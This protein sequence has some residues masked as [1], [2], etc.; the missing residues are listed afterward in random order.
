METSHFEQ[1][2]RPMCLLRTGSS[3]FYREVIASLH[4]SLCN[5]V[6][7][8]FSECLS[9]REPV[10]FLV[11]P[12]TAQSQSRSALRTCP[13]PGA[14]WQTD[15]TSSSYPQFQCINACSTSLFAAVAKSP[16]VPVPKAPCAIPIYRFRAHRFL[17]AQCDFDIWWLW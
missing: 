4:L 8:A 17:R 6:P 9:F 5:P 13:I 2:Q 10:S 11:A 1:G 16:C 12:T 3:D 15:T 14:R 7:S